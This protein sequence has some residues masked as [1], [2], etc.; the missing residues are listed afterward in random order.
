M[1]HYKHKYIYV[2]KPKCL[3]VDKYA[4]LELGSAGERLSFT[5]GALGVISTT[6][7]KKERRKW[8]VAHTCNAD[9]HRAEAGGLRILGQPGQ[10][11][12]ILFLK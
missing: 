3:S 12:E 10:F 11:S 4:M 5:L 7:G 6:G 2:R 9:T 1:L 8:T